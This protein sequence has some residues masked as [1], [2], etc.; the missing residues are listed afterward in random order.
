MAKAK[1]SPSSL[2]LARVASTC[3]FATPFSYVAKACSDLCNLTTPTATK[4]RATTNS[5]HKKNGQQGI[6]LFLVIIFV[7][8]SMS[9]HYGHHAPFYLEK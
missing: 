7:M 1:T 8:L 5:I 4:P 6:A 3:F 9:W 2:A